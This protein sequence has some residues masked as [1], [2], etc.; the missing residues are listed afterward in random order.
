MV[1]EVVLEAI[2]SSVIFVQIQDKGSGDVL[3]RRGKYKSCKYKHL[4]FI[5]YNF[6][7]FL[8]FLTGTFACV[9]M[10]L[11]EHIHWER[12]EVVMKTKKGMQKNEKDTF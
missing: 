11:H 2:N 8:F 10:Q 6:I 5:I 3:Q 12:G 4:C 1:F 7:I 9:L